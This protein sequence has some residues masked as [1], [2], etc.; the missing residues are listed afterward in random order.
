MVNKFRASSFLPPITH[1]LLLAKLSI[2]SS[3][4]FQLPF[5]SQN[6]IGSE[7]AN[8]HLL[9]RDALT[10]TVLIIICCFN[11]TSKFF[12]LFGDC[13]HCL[14]V[15]DDCKFGPM[16]GTCGFL[17]VIFI[18]GSNCFDTFM[19]HFP[20]SIQIQ[21]LFH[22]TCIILSIGLL[23]LKVHSS[24]T[25]ASILSVHINPLY[26]HKALIHWPAYLYNFIS[27]SFKL[28]G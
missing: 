20:F 14:W 19:F 8:L 11:P 23:V 9:V 17:W 27:H 1:L 3:I 24:P 18:T 7:S 25:S 5:Y 2:S 4:M 10:Q 16:L 13:H 6:I 26:T 28:C 22:H 21:S 15:C 12:Q